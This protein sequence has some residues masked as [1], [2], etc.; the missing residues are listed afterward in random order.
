M[1]ITVKTVGLEDYLEGGEGKIKLLLAGSPGAGKT[2]FSSYAP[3]PI[4]GATEDGLLSVADR[5]VPYARIQGEADM[6]DFLTLLERECKRPPKDRRWETVVIDTADAYERKVVSD[7]LRSKNQKEME[8]WE[9]YGWLKAVMNGMVTRLMDLPMNVILLVHTKNVTREGQIPKDQVILRLTGDTRESLPADFD[10][11][12]LFESERKAVDGVPT[13]TRSIR[14]ESTPSVQWL[15]FRGGAV[16]STDVDFTEADFTRIRDVIRA[17]LANVAASEVIEEVEH[18]GNAAEPVSVPATGTALPGAKSAP[19]P[20]APPTVAQQ[21]AVPPAPPVAAPPPAAP[22]PDLT[23]P[24]A[25]E[26]AVANVKTAMPGSTVVADSAGQIPVDPQPEPQ[27]EPEAPVEIPVATPVA[28]PDLD[29]Q[30]AAEADGSPTEPADTP[31]E[32]PTDGV[33]TVAC[34]SPR[35]TGVEP[36]SPFPG[37]GQELVVTLEGNRVIACEG[38]NA[39]LVEMAGIRQRQFL[40]NPDFTKARQA[41]MQNPS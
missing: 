16:T 20:P 21:R 38:Q 24:V 22:K 25:P 29:D 33:I 6:N 32:I 1:A 17:Q 23:P 3:K 30:A 37:C 40:C 39:Q 34:G 18:I 15:K 2:R 35:F 11:V 8:G 28:T 4:Y 31:A 14:W 13:V 27:P 5:N 41:A 9:D 36:T 26:Q 7:Y 12:G 10:F 19:T